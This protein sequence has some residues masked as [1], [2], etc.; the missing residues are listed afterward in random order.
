MRLA[1]FRPGSDVADDLA[2]VIE[3]LRD[4]HDLRLID[5]RAAHD[6]VWQAAQGAFDL[7]VYE[8]DDTLRHQYIWPYLLH[9]P[10]VLALRTSA[11]HDGRNIALVHQH[12]DADRDAEMVFTDG[13]GRPDSPWPL[14]RGAWSTWRV[15]VLASRLT[16]VA[17]AALSASIGEA[18]P[19]S[20]VVITPTGVAD[21][22]A[23]AAPSSRSTAIG[24]R[25]SSSVPPRTMDAALLRAHQAGAAPLTLVRELHAADVVV[26]TQWPTFGRPLLDAL[27]GF[28]AGRAVIVAETASTALW[29]SLDPQTW[30]T[31][32]ISVGMGGTEPPIAISIDPRDE[33]HSLTLALTRLANDAALRASLGRA[34]RAWWEQHAT[35]SH[36]VAAWRQ[37]LDE[38]RAIAAPARPAGWPAHLDADGSGLA[39]S[40]LE[41]FGL[42]L[43][44]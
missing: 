10:G 19:T 2:P 16:V 28:A 30:Q 29:P 5:A 39:A 15:P 42:G 34:A 18:C 17:D 20:R 40:I 43:W 37:L 25:V 23:A 24:V 41:Q 3:G 22:N 27:T 7:C 44:A 8:L 4:T 12:R 13:A 31:R 11:L 32:S 38:A 6:F 14:L 9:Y 35:V 33:E 1:W 36:A 21:P 26:A